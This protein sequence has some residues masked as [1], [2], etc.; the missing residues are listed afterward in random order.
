VLR[1][2]APFIGVPRAGSAEG[3]ATRKARYFFGLES[4]KLASQVF[5]ILLLG[6]GEL[7]LPV[8]FLGLCNFGEALS[9]FKRR[10]VSSAWNSSC[11]SAKPGVGRV[12]LSLLFVSGLENSGGR[13]LVV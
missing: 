8:C 4:E 2:R 12:S 10:T 13:S 7:L 5:H 3:N 9:A 1:E 11:S 6:M